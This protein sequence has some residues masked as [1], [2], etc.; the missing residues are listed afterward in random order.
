[1]SLT[2]VISERVCL[3]ALIEVVL[4]KVHTDIGSFFV[5]ISN[6]QKAQHP[7]N[8]TNENRQIPFTIGASMSCV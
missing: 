4:K 8:S 5:E 6:T 2:F 1:M 3:R 7:P